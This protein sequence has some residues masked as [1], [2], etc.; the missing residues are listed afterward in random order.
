MGGKGKDRQKPCR[1]LDKIGGSPYIKE[2]GEN[3]FCLARTGRLPLWK[4]AVGERAAFQVQ[5][6]R[7]SSLT[8]DPPVLVAW[9]RLLQGASHD[10][11]GFCHH[12]V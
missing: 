8:V 6:P 9:L 11:L 12:G 7:L 4:P 1:G 5:E 3:F 10:P 2:V